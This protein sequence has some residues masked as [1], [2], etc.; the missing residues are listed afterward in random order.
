[1]GR[2]GQHGLTRQ[3]STLLQ[4]FQSRRRQKA[5]AAFLFRVMQHILINAIEQMARQGDVELLGFTQ[6]LHDILYRP[7]PMPILHTSD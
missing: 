5:R 3:G 6:V 7:R 4:N 2:I 1:M